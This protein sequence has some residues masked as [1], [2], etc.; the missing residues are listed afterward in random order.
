MRKSFPLDGAGGLGREVVQY[1]VDALDLVRDTSDDLV[2][3]GVGDLLDGGGHCVLGIDGADDGGPALVAAVVLHTDAL[4]VGD[5]DEILP[6][7]FC[8]AAL[9]ELIAQ[10]GICLAQGV[11]TVAR[12][13]AKATDTKT[14][15]G[16]RLTVNHSVGKTKC[17]ADH[18]HL[19]L[20]K[21]LEGL[22]HPLLTSALL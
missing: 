22:D 19:V 14:G 6:G 12:D 1:A 3:N 11:Q 20:E 17:L 16:E 13:G 4:D 21:E 2:Q 18:A 9:V 10:D 8:K 5:G 15:A 7:L